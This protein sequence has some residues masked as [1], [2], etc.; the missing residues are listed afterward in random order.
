MVTGANNN[1]Y[2]EMIYEGGS[3]FTIN[4]GRIELTKTTLQKPISK[5]NS[6]YNEKVK[7]GYKDITDLVSVQITESKGDGSSS[8]K[9]IKNKNVNIFIDLMR[10]YTD[11]LVSKTYSVKC[12]N[13]SEKQI[14]EAQKILDELTKMPEDN[15]NDINEKLI[16]LYTIIPRFMSNT[17]RHLLPNI[18]FSKTL[19]SEQDNLDAMS[20]QVSVYQEDKK[21]DEKP[22]KKDKGTFLDTL[23][24]EMDEVDDLNTPE[25]KYIID[26]LDK[27]KINQ[28]F[29]VNKNHEN[30]IF[31]NWLKQQNNKQTRH[32]IHGTRCTSVI[33]ILREGLKIRPAGNYQFSGKVYGEG[34][35]FSEVTNKSLN[36]TGYD[37]DRIL[38]IY[39]VHT[40]NPFVYNGWYRGN[41]FSLNYKELSKRGYDSTHVSAGG[42]L[43]NSEIIVYNENQCRVKYIIWLKR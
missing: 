37:N 10:K 12:D 31:D 4:Y 15:V 24:I 41:S 14:K 18:D 3:N 8:Y 29:K 33:P 23:N 2:Y 11:N 40:G 6:I 26:Q 16:E 19:S 34:N 42:G 32:L 43:L 27:R 21:N 39:E 35:Y 30:N 20:F 1:K 38:I 22:E 5:W 9:E 13:V 36:Y 28:V 17:K 7:K 25:I